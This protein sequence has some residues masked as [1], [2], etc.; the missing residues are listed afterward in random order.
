MRS[1]SDVAARGRDDGCSG[2]AGVCFWLVEWWRCSGGV[3]SFGM[4]SRMLL[5]AMD[6]CV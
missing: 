4:D 1:W 5:V 3:A 2:N 6:L